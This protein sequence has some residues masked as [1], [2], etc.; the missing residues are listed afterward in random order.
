MRNERD[1]REEIIKAATELIGE[2]RGSIEEI[3]TRAIAE[4][5][6]VGVGLVNYHFQTKEKLLELCVQQL[7]GS[8]IAQ[9]RP[10]QGPELTGAAFL[11][12]VAKQVADYLVENPAVSQI[13][14]LGD[15]KSPKELDN[16]MKTVRGL[17]AS[18]R[19]YDMP[20]GEKTMLMFTLASVL[21]E[22]FLRRD[23][24]GEL[25]GYDFYDKAQRDAFIDFIVGKLL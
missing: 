6:R 17:S 10:A 21:Q 5:A 22:M 4:R 12:S 14:I 16:T 25:F 19:G 13:S 23:L 2:S 3:T 18:M 11:A 24:S 15:L 9:F 20:D 7:I 1:A 8:F